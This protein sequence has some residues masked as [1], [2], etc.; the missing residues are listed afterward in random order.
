MTDDDYRDLIGLVERLMRDARC[1]ELA[2]PMH[3]VTIREGETFVVPPRERLIQMLSAFD[4]HLAL[5]D[6]TV[7]S[8]ASKRIATVA[9]N[10]PGSVVV[11]LPRE[12]ELPSEPFDLG[13]LPSLG[14]TR[15]QLKALIEDIARDDG[16]PGEPEA[17]A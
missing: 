7:F 5:F 4:R 10:W 14:E 11:E 12:T 17:H 13:R 6:R 1:G 3:Y 16:G 9:R 8:Q 15:N 2:N